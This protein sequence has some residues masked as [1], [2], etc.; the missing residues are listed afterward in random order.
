M[1]QAIHTPKSESQEHVSIFQKMQNKF[2]I[3]PCPQ[4]FLLAQAA[5]LAL[6][7]PPWDTWALL[8]TS[9]ILLK[10]QVAWGLKATPRQQQGRMNA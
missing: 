4:N 6:W 2:K 10:S 7:I 8:G 3:C 1:A 5:L 9:W